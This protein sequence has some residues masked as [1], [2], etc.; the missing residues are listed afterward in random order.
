[1]SLNIDM[2]MIPSFKLFWWI[3]QFR[4]ELLDFVAELQCGESWENIP[5]EFNWLTIN[6]VQS[7]ALWWTLEPR[8]LVFPKVFDCGFWFIFQRHDTESENTKTFACKRL[9]TS[10]SLTRDNCFHG[11]FSQL[12]WDTPKISS[13][14]SSINCSDVSNIC[15]IVRLFP[16]FLMERK[17]VWVILPMNTHA[18]TVEDTNIP[19]IIE[20]LSMSCIGSSG[21]RSNIFRNRS[22]TL[23]RNDRDFN[24]MSDSAAVSE[25]TSSSSTINLSECCVNTPA[26]CSP[27]GLTFLA[28]S[29]SSDFHTWEDHFSSVFH[30][31]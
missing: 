7:S 6:C 9:M 2:K 16:G 19:Q 5:L 15:F 28:S 11:E 22:F 23:F 25:S 8:Q 12:I 10:S 24:D 4:H 20:R 29:T 30:S 17:V 1:M 26:G 18:S 13:D 21:E 3:A 14:C 27:T 31:E